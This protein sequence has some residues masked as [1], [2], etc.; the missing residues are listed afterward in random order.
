MAGARSN[1]TGDPRDDLGELA[2][3]AHLAFLGHR[4]FS[5]ETSATSRPSSRTPAGE[6]HELDALMA[7]FV[8]C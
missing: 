7:I 3:E 4:R 6:T 2:L 1:L 8:G 5:G